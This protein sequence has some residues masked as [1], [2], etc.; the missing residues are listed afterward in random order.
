MH[1]FNVVTY[2][3]QC[4][5]N[6]FI[7]VIK[8][9]KMNEVTQAY[10]QTICNRDKGVGANGLLFVDTDV[11]NYDFKMDYY[12]NDGTWETMCANGALCVIKLLIQENFEFKYKLFL[13]GD[14]E[15]ELKIN[16]GNPSIGMRQ[17]VFKTDDIIVSGHKG[18]HVDS[19]AKHFVIQT[20][21]KNVDAL[22]SLAQKIR[23]DD[24]FA[25]AGIN[26]NFLK[27]NSSNQIEVVTYEKGIEEI[28][29]SC[30]S[31]SV[32]AAFYAYSRVGIYSPLI[33]INQGGEMSLE[34]NDQWTEVW[35]TSNPTI[36]FKV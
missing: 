1:T 31:G 20:E 30:G 7:I 25:P 15:H 22:Y 24:C 4:N 3:A 16:S 14:G 27:V 29:L 9:R 34:F 33:I 19:G 26:V 21:N 35:L 23:Y 10:I 5:G 13:A 2:K 32:A 18:A 8:S 11:D 17:P 12:N 36:E 6:D 28:M